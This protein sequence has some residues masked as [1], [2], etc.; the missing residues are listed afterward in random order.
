M[1]AW[2]ETHYDWEMRLGPIADVA[3]GAHVPEVFQPADHRMAVS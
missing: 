1:R 3:G 2:V